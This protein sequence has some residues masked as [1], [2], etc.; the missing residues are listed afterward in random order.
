M[1]KEN[2]DKKLITLLESNPNFVDEAGVLHR[3]NVRD[4][5][6]KLDPELITLLLTDKEIEAKFFTA[7]E[8]RWIF[9]Y[10]IFVDYITDKNFFADSYTQFRNKIGLNIDGKF[11]SERGEVALVWPYKDCVLEGGQTREEEKRKEIFFNEILA[12]DEINRMFDPKVLTNWKRHTANGEKEEKN[13]KRDENGTLRE[14]LIIKGN[15]LI[16][17]HCLKEQLRGKVK[18]I[19]IDPP[20]NTG[21][22]ANIFT[23][24]N[25][26][27]HSSW[28]T[29]MKNRLDVAKQFLTDDGFIAISID[30]YELLY[31]GTLADEIFGR[32]NRISVLTIV[33]HPAGKTNNNFFAT[34][35]EFMVIYAKNR[36]LAKINFFEMSEKTE[37]TYNLAD[38]ISKYKLENLMR[39][40]ETRNARREDRPKQF[41]P[42]YVS[43][44]LKQISLTKEGNYHEVLPK[45]NG[46][47]WVWS[48]SPSTLQEKIDNNEVV[49]KKHKDG[50]IQ[51]FFKR[52]IIDYE[53]ERPKTAWTDKK[54]NAT[55]HGTKLLENILGKKSFS[56]PKSLHAIVDIVKVTTDPG[57]IVLDFFAGSGTT[58]HAVLELNKLEGSNRQFILVEQLEEHITVCKERLEKVIAQQGMLSENFLSCELM[59]YNEVFM[60]RIQSVQSSK[61][62]LDIWHD[63]SK[64][65][66]LNWYVKPHK[67]EEAEEHFI[68]IDDLEKQKQLLAEL[69]DKNQLYVHFSEIADETFDVNEA[70][71]A[72]NK[73]FYGDSN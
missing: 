50:H 22:E 34:T 56:Y 47:E 13:I 41:Y 4:H 63:I 24:N 43:K 6:W 64:N 2:F 11:L 32:E 14:N 66:V 9:N 71:K 30:N 65:S 58:G 12:P 42:I 31:L 61:E 16:T 23:Y 10:N 40:G 25:T 3:A 1:S 73:A 68:A 70:D 8:G 35:N 55:Q 46:I 27:N 62:L 44:D 5:A 60:E 52:R 45:E 51:I 18:L 48:N 33:H 69:L 37:K 7:I 59:P 54:Y 36:E 53:G 57:D 72:L 15:N 26:F 39:K 49:A 17:L 38:E 67:P 28:L 19:Y 21:G 29:F 20:Y